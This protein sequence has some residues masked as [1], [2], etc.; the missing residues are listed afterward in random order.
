MQLLAQRE[1]YHAEEGEDNEMEGI[2]RGVVA[3]HV[4]FLEH[5][6]RLEEIRADQHAADKLPD[7]LPEPQLVGQPAAEIGGEHQEPETH[8]L[9]GQRVVHEPL[10]FA[11]V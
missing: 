5:P 4:Q 9:Y 11:P 6:D 3:V 8:A 7:H 10:R 1:G 2:E